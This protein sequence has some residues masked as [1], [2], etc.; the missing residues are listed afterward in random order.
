[1][2]KFSLMMAFL[3]LT[4]CTAGYG[5]EVLYDDTH[6]QTAGNADWI[7]EGAYS[8]MADMLKENG[9]VISSLSKV[10]DKK[11][12]S[13]D[14]LSNYQAVILAEPNDPYADDEMKAILEFVHNGGG[15]FIIADHAGADRN[16][17][18][19]DAVKAFNAF[20]PAFGFKFMDN[21]I[22]EAP[23]SGSIN[24][25]HPAMFGVRAV[26]AWAGSTMELVS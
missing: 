3:L 20:T 7:P 15:L 18:G 10:A 9:F 17:N 6:A 16:N 22:Y 13:A 24:S 26:G 12:I 1:M 11:K 4:V 2:K 14:L 23:L 8:E 19:W 5:A 25:S 21:M